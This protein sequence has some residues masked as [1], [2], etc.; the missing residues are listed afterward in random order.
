MRSCLLMQGRGAQ[1][2]HDCASNTGALPRCLHSKRCPTQGLL[3]EMERLR[4]ERGWRQAVHWWVAALSCICHA[5]FCGCCCCCS[6]R[7]PTNLRLMAAGSQD[8]PALLGEIVADAKAEGEGLPCLVCAARQPWR[9][10]A[11]L[12]PCAKPLSHSTGAGG[13]DMIVDD[14]SHIP[15]EQMST[16]RALWPA[17]KPGGI[18]VIE[19]GLHFAADYRP[20]FVHAHA[21]VAAANACQPDA[22]ACQP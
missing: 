22:A 17:I 6:N 4:G 13:F 2:A 19:V 5:L 8:D 14:G 9:N 15:Q 10:P 18:Y 20:A 21:G 1:H 12:Q 7:H 11:G 16:L 3:C